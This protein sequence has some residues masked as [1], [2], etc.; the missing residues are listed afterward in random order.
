MVRLYDSDSNADDPLSDEVDFHLL[1][2][3][4][5]YYGDITVHSYKGYAVING[6]HTTYLQ[7]AITQ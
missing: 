1:L 3:S 7:Y 5:V 4:Y 2:G 6:D